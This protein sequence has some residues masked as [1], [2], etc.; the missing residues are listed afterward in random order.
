MAGP[1]SAN[2]EPRLVRVRGK[3]VRKVVRAATA[4][5][6]ESWMI[7]TKT[8]GSL[9]LK[10]IDANPLELGPPPAEP[11]REIEAEGYIVRNELRYVS[12]KPLSP[13]R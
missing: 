6:H 1:R 4:S 12:V 11:G 13:P 10:N 2:D 5:K 9:L 7:E 3:L 8:H